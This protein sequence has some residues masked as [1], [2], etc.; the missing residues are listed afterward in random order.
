MFSGGVVLITYQTS[1]QE[2][3]ISFYLY[4][5]TPLAVII[6]NMVD[7][8]VIEHIGNYVKI[9]TL[10]MTKTFCFNK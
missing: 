3:Q 1:S 2:G 10:K 9:E 8:P 5:L 7:N 6:D 4:C